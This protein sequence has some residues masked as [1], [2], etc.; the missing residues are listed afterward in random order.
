MSKETRADRLDSWK[1]IAN[2]LSK[3]VRTVR[4]WEAQEGLP[5]HR[6]MHKAQGSV[7]AYRSEIDAWRQR[8]EQ[9]IPDAAAAASQ[10]RAPADE[11]TPRRSIAVLP[12]SYL[13]RDA[14][15]AYIA[16]GF[17]A[18]IITGLSRVQ[19]L[20]VISFTSSMTLKEHRKD[21]RAIGE[22]LN[23]DRVVEGTVQHEETRI[24]VAARLVDAQMDDRIWSQTYEGDLGA[25]FHIQERLAREIVEFLGLHMAASDGG[26]LTEPPMADIT[27]WQCLVQARQSALRWQQDA[28]DHAV[29]LLQHGLSLVGEDARL[30]AALG[31]TWLHYREAG[32]DLSNRPLMEAQACAAKAAALAPRLAA[33]H[34]LAGWIHY[35]EANIQAAVRALGTALEVEPWD[36]DSLSLQANCYLISGK[37]NE[38][39]PLIDR[40]VSVDPLTPLTRCMPGWADALEG[41][42]EAALGP[43]RDMF[44]MDPGNPLA[45]L[46]Y[47]YILAAAGRRDEGR[48]IANEAPAAIRESLPG[49]VLAHFASALGD[50]RPTPRVPVD[51]E[52]LAGGTEMFPRFLA[53]ACTLAGAVDEAVQWASVAVERGFINHAFLA[54]HDPFLS[55]L[56]GTPAYDALLDRVKIDSE[57]FEP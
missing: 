16:D 19:A 50:E 35:A 25:L 49:Q 32:V 22:A 39:R 37:V 45:R 41:N 24:R 3:S 52:L 6:Q 13:G 34:Q 31:R 26:R 55:K 54:R 27:A 46:F 4:R 8:M 29:E 42:F 57:R 38:A 33:G 47:V 28:I 2:Y 12:F 5:V 53:Q 18:E 11:I 1:A 43:Y 56:A 20:R 10:A 44:T 14:D 30:Y 23:V 9:R 21:V 15:T 51:I 36:P 40:L 7:Y 17:T 48:R